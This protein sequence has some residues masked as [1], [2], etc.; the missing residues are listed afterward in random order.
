LLYG[1]L[2]ACGCLLTAWLWT[3]LQ[4][5]SMLVGLGWLGVGAVY[6]LINTRGLRRV[7]PGLDLGGS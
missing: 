7:P 5:Q 2:P 4:L 1:A 6:L 3:S